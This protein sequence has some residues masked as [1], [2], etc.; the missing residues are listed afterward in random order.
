MDYFR[1]K[2]DGHEMLITTKDSLSFKSR[3][4]EFVPA[5]AKIV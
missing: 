4:K 2:E 3:G 1:V 5:A